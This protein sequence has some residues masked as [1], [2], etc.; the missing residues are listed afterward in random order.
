MNRSLRARLNP[1]CL[2]PDNSPGGIESTITLI[3]TGVVDSLQVGVS[4]SH[5]F[6]GDLYVELVAPTGQ[7]ATLHNRTGSS[8]DNVQTVYS[9]SNTPSLLA[10]RGQP[11][12]GDWTLRVKDLA[13]PRFRHTRAL[14][15]RDRLSAGL[16]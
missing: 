8:R 14:E 3:E 7:S 9:M 2:L 13:G 15:H 16:P 6:I 4:I 12:A 5:P 1:L 11:V 10:L